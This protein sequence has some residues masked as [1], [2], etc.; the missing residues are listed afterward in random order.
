MTAASLS[1][2]SIVVVTPAIGALLRTEDLADSHGPAHIPPMNQAM[3][4]D[5]ERV[6]QL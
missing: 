4:F 5:A 1:A 2:A 3:E 6:R